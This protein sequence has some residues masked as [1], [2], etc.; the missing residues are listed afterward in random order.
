MESARVIPRPF[1]AT[2]HM[3]LGEDDVPRMVGG[4]VMDPEFGWIATHR[5]PLSAAV[6]YCRD[7][8]TRTAGS[9]VA[10]VPDGAD[11][12]PYFVMVG[13]RDYYT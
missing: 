6:A 2:A 5:L 11:P 4:R 13:A 7:F 9:L 3:I 12:V 1:H 10:I 8:R